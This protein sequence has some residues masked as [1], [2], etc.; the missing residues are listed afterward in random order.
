M[1]KVEAEATVRGTMN[2][3]DVRINGANL[4]IEA[5]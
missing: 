5:T 1:R 2:Q 3:I 4:E